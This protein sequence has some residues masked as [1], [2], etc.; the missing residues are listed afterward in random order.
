[1]ELPEIHST[2]VD[3]VKVTETEN[4]GPVA[5]GAGGS[6]AS[7][8]L[9]RLTSF[10]YSGNRTGGQAD[11]ACSPVRVH[12]HTGE[13]AV[14]RQVLWVP[15]GTDQ[16]AGPS[17]PTAVTLSPTTSGRWRPSSFSIE[18]NEKGR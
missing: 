10:D 12:S 11:G 8:L 16:A 6:G 2:Y 1:M 13:E 17:S 14:K 3:S 18:R 4:E 15:D 5:V 9:K 7:S